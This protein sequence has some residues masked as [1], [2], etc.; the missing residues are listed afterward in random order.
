MTTTELMRGVMLALVILGAVGAVVSRKKKEYRISSI[1]VLSFFVMFFIISLFSIPLLI[2]VLVSVT[3]AFLTVLAVINIINIY[4]C[5]TKLEAI[6]INVRKVTKA[7]S[8]YILPVFEYK[9]QGNTYRET[10][11]LERAHYT[12]KKHEE[13]CW[14]PI[15]V[16]SKQP[17]IFVERRVVKVTHIIFLATAF[18]FLYGGVFV[19]YLFLCE[20]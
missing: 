13:G 11:V 14:Y 4:R 7:S 12:K 20:L 6:V 16:N 17:N 8:V 2:G 10:P 1:V 19:I 3:G 9:Y 15:Y 18:A 5:D